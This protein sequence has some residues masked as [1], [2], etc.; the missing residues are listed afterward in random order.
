MKKILS[1]ACATAF[2]FGLALTAF[3]ANYPHEFADDN[4]NLFSAKSAYQIDKVAGAVKVVLQNGTQNTYTDVSGA[5]YTK[6]VN[7]MAAGG[8]GAGNW[9][10]LPGTLTSMNISEA[11]NIGC[12]GSGNTQTYFSY[13]GGSHTK[14]VPDNCAARAAIAAQ[15]N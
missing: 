3:A 15:S 4:G 1:R 13:Y 11:L 9:Y 10:T 6:L 12:Y 7:Y 5:L 2:L 8:A 14:F